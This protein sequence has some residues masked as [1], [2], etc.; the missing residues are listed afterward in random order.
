[1]IGIILDRI[2]ITIPKKIACKA[3]DTL[4]KILMSDWLLYSWS[5]TNHSDGIAQIKAA[6]ILGKTNMKA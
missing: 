3:D 2:G 4:G 5:L 6:M 1:V